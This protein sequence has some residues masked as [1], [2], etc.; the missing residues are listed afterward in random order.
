MLV[1]QGG[2]GVLRRVDEAASE[3]RCLQLDPDLQ[4]AINR[5]LAEHNT[6]HRHSPLLGQA[7]PK[8]WMPPGANASRFRL[9]RLL[10]HLWLARSERF[11]CL[12]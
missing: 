10:R 1:S 6:A 4:A 5:Y 9:D 8:P 11:H 3:I 2:R 7:T 12:V